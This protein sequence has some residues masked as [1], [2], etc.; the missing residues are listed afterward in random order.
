MILVADSGSTKADWI[1]GNNGS[2][3][4]EFNTKGFN[5]FFHDRNFILT[6]LNGNSALRDFRMNVSMLYFFGAGCS[7]PDRNA[8][9]AAGLSEF[10]PNAI[11]T[12]EHDMLGSALAVCN[13]KPGMAC[14]LGTGSNICYFD[15]KQ[16]ADTRHGLGYIIGDEGS[17]SYYGKKLLAWY[18]YKIL[19]DDL[20]REF[21]A[22]YSLDKEAII[23]Q[24][25]KEA[26][27]NVFLASFATFLS[28]H[29][30]HPFIQEMIYN[31][32]SEFFNTNVLSYPESKSVPVHFVGSIAWYF[33]DILARVAAEKDIQVGNIIRKP[34]TG[35]AEYFLKG[36][37]MP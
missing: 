20:H 9:I 22:S 27:P 35:L 16:I 28:D 26:N 34:V 10:F 33:R 2:M 13:G 7:S 19:P 18:L 6:E 17:G 4:A 1:A 15:G 14:I 24:V 21:S 32:M 3:V 25:Y 31:G 8:I 12:V 11:I 36:G 30:G 23:Q 5:P 37:R 29:S